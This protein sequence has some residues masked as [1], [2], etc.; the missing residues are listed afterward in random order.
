MP[1]AGKTY[2][3]RQLAAELT[4]KGVEVDA[5]AIEIG[6]MHRFRRIGWKLRLVAR[7]MTRQPRL[8]L[9]AFN[10]VTASRPAALGD[11]GIVF[12]NWLFLFGVIERNRSTGAVPVL[13]QGVIQ[14][15]WSTAYFARKEIYP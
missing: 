5:L 15:V 13:D 3:A 4:Q 8:C 14:A 12:F 11:F 9:S 1:A 6:Q 2:T 10:L 7:A